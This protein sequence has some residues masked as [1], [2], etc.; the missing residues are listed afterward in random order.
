MKRFLN[1]RGAAATEM[2]LVIPI[3]V[4]LAFGLLEG[5]R[6]YSTTTA[7]THAAREA[8]RVVALGGTAADAS[9]RVT[10]TGVSGATV[11]TTACPASMTAG[12]PSDASVTVSEPF[13]FNIPFVSLTLP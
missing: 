3:F 1:E 13:T 4:M 5:G 7:V 6:Y 2:A 11:S 12:S 10:A 9:N 8:V